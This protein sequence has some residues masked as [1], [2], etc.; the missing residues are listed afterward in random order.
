MNSPLGKALLAAIRGGDYAHPGEEEAIEMVWAGLPHAPEQAVLD[1]GCGRAGTAAYVQR[2]GWGQ[3][4][5]FDIDVQSIATAQITYPEL[6]LV[7]SDVLAVPL[8]LAH[9]QPAG[10]DVVYLFTSFYAFPDQPTSLRALRALARRGARFALFDYTDADGHFRDSPPGST[11]F[12]YWKPVEPPKLK[13]DLGGADWRLDSAHDLTPDFK[14]WY[15]AF[16]KKIATRRKVLEKEFTP[17]LV[18]YVEEYYTDLLGT[19]EAGHLGG[20]LAYATAV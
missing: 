11:R 19:I 20:T 13:A 15:K 3:V 18:D 6:R 14:R 7:A 17:E 16:L 10:F 9:Q 8:K 2:H 1:A 5:G 12:H 4:T